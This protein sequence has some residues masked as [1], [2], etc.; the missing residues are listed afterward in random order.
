MNPNRAI[1]IT[2]ILCISSIALGYRSYAHTRQAIVSDLNQALQRSVAQN[3]DL[4]LNQD[5][6]RTYSRLQEI[7]GAPVSVSSS[8]RDFTE[9][10]NTPKLKQVSGISFQII[11]KSE[12]M[13]RLM[14]DEYLTS[15]TLLWLS[16]TGEASSELTLSFQGYARC[17]TGLIL[18]LSDQRIPASLLIIALLWGAGSHLFFRRKATRSLSPAE[19]EEAGISFG[20]LT[21]CC[22]ENCFYNE[23][24]EKLKFTP[25]QYALMEMFYLS[26]SHQLLKSDICQALWPGKE[27]ADETLYT[28]IRRLKPIVEEQSNLKITTDRG[29]AY[30]LEVKG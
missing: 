5:S 20:N 9:A 19:K 24:K 26:S 30:S 15:D 2:L 4:W 10:L 17:S 29:R 21:L 28:L 23:Q 6:I 16:P 25:L 3:M 22:D 27:N 7:M 14:P 13:T 11:K 8:N 1:L 18:S 12:K